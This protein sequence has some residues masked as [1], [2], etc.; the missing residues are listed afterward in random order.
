MKETTSLFFLITARTLS[1]FGVWAVSTAA[2]ST[3]FNETGN[4]ALMALLFVF[5]SV[6]ALPA[7]AALFALEA[8]G[9]T[10]L[11]MLPHIELLRC[12]LYVPIVFLRSDYILFFLTLAWSFTEALAMPCYFSLAPALSSTAENGKAINRLLTATNAAMLLSPAITGL[13]ATRFSFEALSLG[14]AVLFAGSAALLRFLAVNAKPLIST[15]HDECEIVEVGSGGHWHLTG[16]VKSIPL[17]VSIFLLVDFTSGLAFGTLN[18]LM[19]VAAT[20]TSSNSVALYGGFLSL[21]MAGQLCGNVVY[22]FLGKRQFAPNRLYFLATGFSLFAYLCFGWVS[23]WPL[24]CAMLFLTG[25]GNSVQDVCL[26]T[27]LQTP[28][29]PSGSTRTIALRESLGSIAVL[30]SSAAVA[31]MIKLISIPLIVTLSFAVATLASVAAWSRLNG[32]RS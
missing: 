24:R 10:A 17:F 31:A 22:E 15:G 32:P 9:H 1:C 13:L 12:L 4:Y 8:R 18:S 16:V 14:A 28:S 5:R 29:C 3:V 30:L 2:P 27:S 19:P 20:E 11:S 23:W 25:L 21:L 7:N 6:P 26:L